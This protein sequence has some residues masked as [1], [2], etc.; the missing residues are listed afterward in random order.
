MGELG[1]LVFMKLFDWR[2]SKLVS[3]G[4][5][6]V[7]PDCS[8]ASQFDG[9]LIERAGLSRSDTT[10]RTLIAYEEVSI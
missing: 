5:M 4:A 6:I 2:T 10:G 3:I 1:C 8:I 7:D 9:E